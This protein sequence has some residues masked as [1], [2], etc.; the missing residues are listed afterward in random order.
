MA[1]RDPHAHAQADAPEHAPR[2]PLARLFSL[3]RP[4]R[5]RRRTLLSLLLLGL[6]GLTLG[7]VLGLR[8]DDRALIEGVRARIADESD[9]RLIL[10]AA[11]AA[12][13]SDFRAQGGASAGDDSASITV[14]RSGPAAAMEI[15]GAGWS[16]HLWSTDG[17]PLLVGRGDSSGNID[18]RRFDRSAWGSLRGTPW[19]AIAQGAPGGADPLA[20]GRRL[21]ESGCLNSLRL[22]DQESE[23]VLGLV[24]CDPGLI[25]AL[26]GDRGAG[27][28]VRFFLARSTLEISA[29][30]LE[31]R[32]PDRRAANVRLDLYPASPIPAPL[33]PAATAPEELATWLAR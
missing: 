33:I 14:A 21:L 5:F 6:L 27:I 29:I 16:R 4:R 24:L 32:Y 10:R 19:G 11:L 7:L 18:W 23:V 25:E 1:K 28:A 8:S 26:S 2:S 30:E 9:A 13:P 15:F 17:Q 31:L 12:S 20:L 22:P 3:P